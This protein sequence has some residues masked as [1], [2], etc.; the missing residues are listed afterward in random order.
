VSGLTETFSDGDRSQSSRCRRV[1]GACRAL[2]HFVRAVKLG[3]ARYI[4]TVPKKDPPERTG[5]G[6]LGEQVWIC[7]NDRLCIALRRDPQ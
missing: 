7:E 2:Q 6:W 4:L 3:S 1:L 5:R